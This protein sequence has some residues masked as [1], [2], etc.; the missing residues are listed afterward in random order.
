ME[1]ARTMV[2]EARHA[3]GCPFASSRASLTSSFTT[4]SRIEAGQIDP[5]L[6]MLRRILAAAGRSLRLTA[7]AVAATAPR[8]GRSRIRLQP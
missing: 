2:A 4:I 6:G 7:E 1:E 3:A 8:T 5:T